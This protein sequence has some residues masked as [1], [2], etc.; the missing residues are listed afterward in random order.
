MILLAKQVEIPLIVNG[1]FNFLSKPRL[2]NVT[3]C[4]Q[5]KPTFQRV[6]VRIVNKTRILCFVALNTLLRM[7]KIPHHLQCV[8]APDGTLICAYIYQ[9]FSLPSIQEIVDVSLLGP[10][11]IS[12]RC[13]VTNLLK[14]GFWE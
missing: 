3:S 13:R 1:I 10:R 4:S 2:T 14:M 9:C 8:T 5:V 11:R 7:C 6:I 12:F